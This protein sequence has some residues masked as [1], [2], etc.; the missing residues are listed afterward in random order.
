MAFIFHKPVVQEMTVEDTLSALCTPECRQRVEV[1]RM[2]SAELIQDYQD[3]KNKKLYF[4]KK[5]KTL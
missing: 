3:I 2:H 4:I 5:R 1:Y